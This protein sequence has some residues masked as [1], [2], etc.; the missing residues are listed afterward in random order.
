MNKNEKARRIARDAITTLLVAIEQPKTEQEALA[1]MDEWEIVSFDQ[2]LEAKEYN[3]SRAP[4]A[5]Q[6]LIR[7]IDACLA[8]VERVKAERRQS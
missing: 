1:L 5:N 7:H 4:W 6:G 8:N 3:L 2:L